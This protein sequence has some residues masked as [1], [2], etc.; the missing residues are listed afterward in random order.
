[1]TFSCLDIFLSLN[2][3]QNHQRSVNIDRRYNKTE[4]SNNCFKIFA[5]F[6]DEAMRVLLFFAAC[7]SAD[8]NWHEKYHSYDEIRDFFLDLSIENRHTRIIED[9]NLFALMVMPLR[10]YFKDI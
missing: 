5:F 4:I 7:I 8:E 6:L 10:V 1:M 9:G 2:L 3:R